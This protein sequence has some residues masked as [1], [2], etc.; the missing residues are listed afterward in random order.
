MARQAV[1]TV[2][3]VQ[4]GLAVHVK[5]PNGKYIVIDL[6]TGTV[7]SGNTSPLL[8]RRWDS[9]GYMI[10]THPHLDHID[11]ILNFDINPPTILHRAIAI[12]NED[13][14]TG[15]RDCD[16]A[17]F[18]KYCEINNRYTGSVSSSA[19]PSNPANFGGLS[20]DT[21]STNLCDKKN[22]NNFSTITVFELSGC[23]IVVCGDN[24]KESL[25]VL[26]KRVSFREAVQNAH[27]LVAPHHGRESGYHEDFVNLVKPKITIVS[28]SNGTEASAVPKY[29]EKS[30]GWTVWKSD[31]TSSKRWCLTTRNDGNIQVTFGEY[32]SPEYSGVL[33]IELV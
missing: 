27:V 31:G 22:Y 3:D 4:L 2:Y 13:V 18:S 17:K 23:K 1:M 33:V 26:M 14:M 11:D 8:K 30:S 15:V 29:R 21:F 5:A 20:I 10:I 9:I 12:S 28:D 7:R 32:Q 24:Q 19:D 6:G 16:R 25:D